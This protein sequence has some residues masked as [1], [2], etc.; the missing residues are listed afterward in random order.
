VQVASMKK[1][2]KMQ[3]KPVVQKTTVGGFDTEIVDFNGKV[4]GIQYPISYK[5]GFLAAGKNVY[6][7]MTWTLAERKSLHNQSMNDMIRSFRLED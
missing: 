6:M 7:I 4:K 3:G 1:K 5:L 2:L